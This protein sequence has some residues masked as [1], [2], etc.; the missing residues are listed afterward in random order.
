[1]IIFLFVF[2]KSHIAYL[3]ADFI[4]LKC[5]NGQYAQLNDGM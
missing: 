2:N 1:M 3:W 5:G 4:P